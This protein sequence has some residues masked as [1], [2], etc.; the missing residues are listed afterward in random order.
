MAAASD[1]DFV[2]AEPRRPAKKA[3]SGKG[4]KKPGAAPVWL[5][6]LWAYRTPLVGGLALI[7]LLAAIAV[8]AMFLQRGRHPAPLLGSTIRIEAAK[9]VARPPEKPSSIA[10]IIAAPEPAAPR[11]MQQVAQP[12]SPQAAPAQAVPAP[13]APVEAPVKKKN[14]DIGAL[15]SDAAAA[16]PALPRKTILAAQRALQKLGAGVKP[17]G[18]YGVG[19]RKAVEAFQRSNHLPAT[20]ELTPKLRQLLAIQA[21]MAVD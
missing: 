16:A 1:F 3:G 20:G 2:A 15:L 19:T 7:G 6:R 12:V 8:N 10:Q 18:N 13:P 4:R 14:D 11:G 9:P 5:A 17:D 21:G